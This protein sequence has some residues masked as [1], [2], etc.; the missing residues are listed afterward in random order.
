MNTWNDALTQRAQ[1]QPN[2]NEESEPNGKVNR[3]NYKLT[4]KKVGLIFE[5]IVILAAG[6]FIIDHYGPGIWLN[7]WHV[8]QNIF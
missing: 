6:L 3:K 7:I 8:M 4:A 1:A 5:R 2:N